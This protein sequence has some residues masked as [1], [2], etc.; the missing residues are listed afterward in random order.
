MMQRV[1]W[2]VDMCGRVMKQ[3]VR[4]QRRVKSIPKSEFRG[5]GWWAFESR[6]CALRSRSRAAAAGA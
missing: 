4:M 1:M 3:R 2:R 5:F 6:W